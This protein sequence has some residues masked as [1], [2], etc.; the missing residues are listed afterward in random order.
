[1]IRIIDV[2][3]SDLIQEVALAKTSVLNLCWC[4]E[5]QS[6]QKVIF[7]FQFNS[8]LISNFSFSFI[9][10]NQ[11]LILLEKKS[12]KIFLHFQGYQMNQ[13]KEYLIQNLQNLQLI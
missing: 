8:S 3:T 11:K 13:I 2:E 5:K 1:M 12:V 6:T 4:Y 10:R 9:Q 7:F